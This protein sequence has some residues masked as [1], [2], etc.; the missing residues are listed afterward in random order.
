LRASDSSRGAYSVPTG[1]REAGRSFLLLVGVL[2]FALSAG[3][4]AA[5]YRYYR[6][7]RANLESGV[8]SQL[9]AI[10]DL[11]VQRV[12]AWRDER[13]ADAQVLAANPLLEMPPTAENDARLREWMEVF[14]AHAGYDRVALVDGAGHA[15]L[16]AANGFAP[17]GDWLPTLVEAAVRSGQTF[18]SDLHAEPG[19]STFID[20]VAPVSRP[21]TR[22][23][24]AV[25]LRADASESFFPLI[26]SWPTPSR[27][28]ES[29]L[30]RVE[31]N[32][33]R[34]LHPLRYQ[35]EAGRR[36]AMPLA[37]R[38]FAA[39]SVG[40]PDIGYGLDYRGIPVIAAVR[41]VPR[42]S[43]NLVAKTDAAEVYAPL[44]QQS[45]L[46]ALVV[47][48]L[49]GACLATFGFF[50][51]IQQTRAY[52]R[53]LAADLERQ[54]LAERYARLSR[55]IN[56]VV[57]LLDGGG[58]ILEANDRAV[59]T[60]G[61]ALEELLR[62]SAQDLLAAGD[63]ENFNLHWQRLS[64]E[65]SAISELCH[66]RKDGS[67]FAVEVSSRAFVVDG[68]AYRHSVIRD[69][70]DR[71]RAEQALRRATRAV[72]VLSASNHAVIR[73]GDED[74][75]LSDICA[76][77][78]ETGGYP[79]AWVGFAE[80]DLRKPVRVAASAGCHVEYV[81]SLDITW[82]ESPTGSGPVGTAVRTGA[83]AVSND[84][85]ADPGFAPWRERAALFGFRAVLSLP[86]RCEEAVIGA[87]SIYAFEPDAFHSE[88][89]QLL[90]ELAT[91]LSYGLTAR[92]Q[93]QQQA[94][95]EMALLQSAAEFG[96]LFDAAND[97]IFIVDGA[98]RFLEAN[99]VACQRL[100]Y[101]RGELLQMTVPQIEP[102][103]CAADLDRRW[104]E[105][106]ENG[107]ALVET[108]HLRKDGSE[109]P[110]EISSRLFLYRQRPAVL[111]VA[112]DISE[113]KR[114]EA[115]AQARALELERA[116]TEAENANRAK[117]EF[118]AN[119]SHEIRTP[120]NG[121]TGTTGLLL[122]TPLTG[123]QRDYA[124]TIRKC[125]TALLAIVN[126]I[127]DLSKIEAGKMSLEPGAFDLIACLADTGDFCAAQA[128]AKG[129][130]YNFVAETQSCWVW[131]D[132]GR[133]RQIVLNLLSNAIKF[134]DSGRVTLRVTGSPCEEGRRLFQ[135]AV[136]DTGIGIAAEQLPLLFRKFSQ[137]DS[138]LMK[139]REGAGLGLAISRELAELMGGSLAVA[140]EPGKGST[141]LLT[142]P[143]T[144]T[145][146]EHP[147]GGGLEAL[148]HALDEEFRG[149]RRRILVAEDDPVNQ[150]IAV[151]MLEKLGCHVDLA[152][153]GKEAVEMVGR[154]PYDLIFMDCG[155]PEMD[156]F[157]A[158][159]EIRS[160][161]SGT[162]QT[163]IVA[164]TAHVIAGTREQCAAAGMDDYLAKPVT[165]AMMG[166][167]LRKWCA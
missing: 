18:L 147:E 65:A 41:P 95:V 2:L 132:V 58:R 90:E 141:F 62:L 42:T 155:M 61:Y 103:R 64:E 146:P 124:E 89:M 49:L 83:A 30:V 133:I 11:K 131:G 10:A 67:R 101:A 78:T 39:G 121:I 99:Q 17:S 66:R 14:R 85:A 27:T 123:E 4:V 139:K 15:H 79:L 20:V 45:R 128:L 88:E 69:I 53:Q 129:I 37:A 13:I 149:K 97:A 31:G 5:G 114:A 57:L 148:H 135:V 104:A 50:W 75:L 105:L 156:G 138:S 161:K 160:R 43:W 82:D 94:K 130:E 109:F 126:D 12:L 48:L 93:R 44:R 34:F 81:Q 36:S 110:V 73:S 23:I 166:S 59:A 19:G 28:A 38:P 51:H 164:L 144:L 55:Y 35:K 152:S 151:R 33:V 100:G 6:A 74:R 8:Q 125:S 71:R 118:L 47:G 120:M 72:R 158:C 86:L 7:Q 54:A 16:T 26:Q 70:T 167:V 140:S 21:V 84:L 106:M 92:R 96:T 113:R 127:L 107:E 154:F 143:L 159:R 60:Y 122:D 157:A 111:A 76:A 80:S 3:I 77:I 87:L 165:P 102:P 46:A 119:M 1:A 150:K 134:T 136:E 56:D 91:D 142:V 98:A 137:V 40:T 116:K 25:L 32:Q 22:N 162:T 63:E 115:E 163:P 68:R 153:N 24:S 9:S 145:E 112:R 117:S 52:K 29:L 108:V